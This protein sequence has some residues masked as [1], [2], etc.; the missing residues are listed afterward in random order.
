MKNIS[1][2]L[3]GLI[4][5]VGIIFVL[6]LGG[7]EWKKFF[8]PKFQNVERQVFENTQS[9]VHGQNQNL[10]KHFG[11]YQKGNEDIKKS[12]KGI[13]AVQFAQFPLDQVSSLKL[14]QFLTECRGY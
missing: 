11:E 3:F 10:A 8:D 4:A 7:L 13:I 5:I 2:I 14:K 6:N 9:Y 1:K 12:I